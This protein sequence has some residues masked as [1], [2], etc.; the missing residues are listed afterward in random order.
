MVLKPFP[1]VLCV[2]PIWLRFFY[3]LASKDAN[4]YVAEPTL[5]TSQIKSGFCF[6]KSRRVDL[7]FLFKACFWI[8]CV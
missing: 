2:D 5:R 7:V 3:I 4:K 6:N 1:K 8:R